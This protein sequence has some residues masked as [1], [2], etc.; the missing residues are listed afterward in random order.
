MIY[1]RKGISTVA[2]LV[3][4]LIQVSAQVPT[5]YPANYTKA[6]RFKALIYF[7][8]RTE[9]DHVILPTK[10]STFCKSFRL[11]MGLPWIPPSILA[12]TLTKN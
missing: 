2:L 5:N 3:L 1:Y 10:P 9:R 7:S 12:T 11:A 6:P 4:I 8:E